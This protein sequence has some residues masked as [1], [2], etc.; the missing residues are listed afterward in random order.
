MLQHPHGHVDRVTRGNARLPLL[1]RGL[2]VIGVKVSHPSV[3]DDFLHGP[4]KRSDTD[5]I[6][7]EKVAGGTADTYA[8]RYAVH[9]APID[10]LF[11]LKMAG[12]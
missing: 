2:R 10:I 1:P 7:V 6:Y 3:T 8:R 5:F 12:K 4:S 11:S 9:D